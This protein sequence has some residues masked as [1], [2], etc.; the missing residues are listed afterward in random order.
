[1]PAKV[2]RPDIVE[3]K[4]LEYLDDL[5]ESGVVNMFG[6]SSYLAEDFYLDPKEARTIL[7]YWM[8]SF[9]ERHAR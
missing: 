5:R 8:E 6:A 2:E 4:H 3:D 1:M 7:S 9:G